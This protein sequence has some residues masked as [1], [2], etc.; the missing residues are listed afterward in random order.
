MK[1][2][3]KNETKTILLTCSRSLIT[4][5]AGFSPR[6]FLLAFPILRPAS[7]GG[8]A[9]ELLAPDPS[10]SSSPSPAVC[11]SRGWGIKARLAALKGHIVGVP[12]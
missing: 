9:C 12:L 10:R 2:K 7:D 4:T 8:C 11:P 1:R 5:A 3:E 6:S